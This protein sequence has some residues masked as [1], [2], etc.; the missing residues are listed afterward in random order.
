M[1][2]QRLTGASAALLLIDHQVGTMGWVT[3][4][5]FDEMKRNAIILAKAAKILNIPTVLTSSME[6][7]AQGPLLSELEAILPDEFAARIKRAGIVNAM[8]DEAF[9]AAVHATGRTKFIL[10]GVTND[11]CTVY[12][13]LTLVGQGHEVQVVADAGG[14]PSKIADDIALRRMERAGVT[15]TSTNQLIAELA[16]S[17]STPEGGQLVQALNIG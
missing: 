6:E 4:T 2:F 7:A 16:G 10:A 8:D 11:V 13:A 15:L 1:T 14:S 9:A 12:P 5:S 3:S 17:W